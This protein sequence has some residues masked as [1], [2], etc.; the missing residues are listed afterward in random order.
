MSD[1]AYG[2]PT[3][4]ENNKFDRL[5][6]I[7]FKN[8][9]IVA[10]EVCGAIGYLDGSIRDPTTI[11]QSPDPPDFIS[12]TSKPATKPNLKQPPGILMN[13]VLENREP[14]MCGP[15]NSYCTTFVIQLV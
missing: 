14:E 1:I 5:N 4:I 7:A 13:L 11:I 8:L 9:I 10:T 3:F 2:L 6:W 15:K 12:T